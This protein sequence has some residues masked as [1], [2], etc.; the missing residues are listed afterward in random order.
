MRVFLGLDTEPL[1]Q[2][3]PTVAEVYGLSSDLSNLLPGFPVRLEGI[4]TPPIALA[5][6]LAAGRTMG[7]DKAWRI[8]F[9]M[10]GLSDKKN[11]LIIVPIDNPQSTMSIMT[12]DSVNNPLIITVNNN[13]DGQLDEGYMQTLVT[14]SVNRGIE[15]YDLETEP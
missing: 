6:E 5:T 12:S 13:E 14:V 11:Q 2:N 4:E 7:D 8:I 3:E 15:L 1:A 9:G 10:E